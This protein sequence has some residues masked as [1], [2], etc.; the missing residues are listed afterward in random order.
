MTKTLA[1]VFLACAPVFAE[2][3]AMT[4]AERAY[5]LEQ[6]DSS[7][8]EMLA[9]IDGLTEA[10]WKFKAGPDRW[11]IQECAEHIVL[12][13]DYIFGFSQQTLKTPVVSRPATS[14]SEYD[15]KL[16]AGIKDRSK[17]VTA[18]EPITPT[19]KFATPADAAREFTARRAKTIEYVT[20]TNDDLRVHSGQGPA[21]PMDSYQILLLLAAHSSRHTA[22]ILEV[23]ASSG[24]PKTM[25]AVR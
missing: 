16:V 10:Q 13:E 15:R 9:S 7:R 22:Q 11:S 17:K 2:G 19:G 4:A 24:Y 25:A 23:K 14:T 18:P 20:A 21:G 1:L 12:A 5:L 3:G 6:L 8:K